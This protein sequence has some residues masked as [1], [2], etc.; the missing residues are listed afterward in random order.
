MRFASRTRPIRSCRPHLPT[1]EERLPLGDGVLGLLVGAALLP[2]AVPARAAVQPPASGERGASAPRGESLPALG[3]FTLPARQEE[4]WLGVYFEA[5][6][7]A[8]PWG[9]PADLFAR[10]SQRQRGTLIPSPPRE[11]GPDASPLL[12]LRAGETRVSAHA[13]AQTPLVAAPAH[14]DAAVLTTLASMRPPAAPAASA[15]TPTQEAQVKEN[16]GRLPVTFEQNVGQM[17]ASVH[18]FTRGPGYGLFLTST[19]AVMVLQQP[20]AVS[21]QQSAFG[22]GYALPARSASEDFAVTAEEAQEPPA[23]IR[24]QLVGANATPTVIGRAEQPGKV[25]YFLGNDP[26]KWHTNI[27]TFGRVEYDEVY[28]GIDLVWHGSQQQLEYDFV[29]SPGADPTAIR[30]RFAHADRLEI[31]SAGDL[32]LHTGGQQLRQHKPLVYQEASSARQEVASRFVLEGGQVR[33]DVGA[34]DAVRPLVIDPVLS[35]STYLGGSGRELGWDIIVDPTTGDALITGSTTSP[36]FPTVNP[37]QPTNGGGGDAYV[38]R[39]SADGSALVYSTYLG[40]NDGDEG[41][42]IAVDS[43]T[44]DALITGQTASSNFPTANPLQSA[45]RGLTDAFLA[46]LRMD[47]AALVYSTY[48]GGSGLDCGTA[49]AADPVTGDA[50]VTGYTLS[51]DFPTAN[52]L[53]PI[54]GGGLYDSFVVR[55]R[56][57]GAALAYST[58]LGGGGWDRG[59]GIAVDAA[60]RDAF[61]TGRTDSRDFPTANALQPTFGGGSDDV[62]VVRLRADGATL[63]YSTYLGGNSG[64]IGS[65][66][67]VDPATRDA[68]VTG[69]T[70]SSNFPTANPLQQSLRG[71][72]DAFV[73]R[74]RGDG[75]ALVYSTYLGGSTWENGFGI[76]VDLDT[77]EVL[78][79]GST[80]STDFPTANPIQSVY[81]GGEYDVYVARLSAN[82]SALV[83]STYLGGSD[84]EEGYAVAVD[85]RTGDAFVTGRTVSY[86]YP[87]VNALQPVL[88]G[89]SGGLGASCDAFVTRIGSSPVAYYYVYPDGGQVQAGVPFDFYVFALDAQFNVIPDYTGLILFWATDPLATT[90]VYYQFQRTDRG[91]AYFPGGLTFN[92]VGFQELYVFDWP[93]VQVFGYA[94]FDV[95]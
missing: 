33:F 57:D 93:G 16:F 78:V 50:L 40:G 66:I 61:V 69:S 43:F 87:T 77:G 76:A 84:F 91:V 46:R 3:G 85:P 18:F 48:H 20:S 30:L 60:T 42:A 65:G 63:V 94:A 75:S 68:L 7:A 38:A 95:R 5:H 24:M 17:D 71:E 13:F 62:F 35:Y 45:N 73:A 39:L 92:T 72:G 27:S 21:T 58:Y 32:I 56:A 90:P 64:D 29:V 15:A 70:G 22:D 36:D 4:A 49:I 82:G 11:Q 31:D 51:T 55:L 59:Q 12:A 54:H 74:L 19:E 10:P 80:H 83:Y 47:G 86:N 37:F 81:G 9:P 28:P 25:N 79:S 6:Q 8:S 89:C 23:V 41:R 34:Y 2:D 44:G 14:A 1:L 52:A 53:Q 88:G 67:A 26:A